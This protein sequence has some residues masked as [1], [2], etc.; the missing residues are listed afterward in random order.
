MWLM[1]LKDLLLNIQQCAIIYR[2]FDSL[3][4]SSAAAFVFIVERGFLPT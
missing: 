4:G 2:Y 1:K 3:L